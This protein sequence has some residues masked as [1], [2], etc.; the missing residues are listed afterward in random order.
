LRSFSSFPDEQGKSHAKTYHIQGSTTP[1]N[2][3]SVTMKTNTG[4]SLQTDLPKRMGGQDEAPQ[5]VETLLAALTGCTQATA[6][7]VGRQ[8]KPDRLQI[9]RM[10]FFL[11]ATRDERGAL[12]LPI[13][14]N[15]PVPS[16]LQLVTGTIHVFLRQQK[17]ITPNQM[18]ALRE[19][20]ELRCPV[21]NMMLASGC[22]IDVEWIDGSAL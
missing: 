22:E 18:A 9:E 3:S 14:Q 19:Q 21:A 7:F 5:P 1:D 20:T 16:R 4:H 8:M 10:D 17:S 15:P 2:K 12:Q 13:A 11:T 6:L